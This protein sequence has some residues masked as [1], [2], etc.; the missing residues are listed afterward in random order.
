MKVAV[1]LGEGRAQGVAAGR[2]A[3]C[4][5]VALPPGHYQV[6]IG[7]ESM[8]ANKTGSVYHDLTV[9]D[10]HRHPLTLSHI[11]LEQTAGGVQLPVARAGT[12]AALLPAMPALGREFRRSERA[13]A[14][15]RVYRTKAAR[16]ATVV[17]VATLTA[18]GSGERVWTSRSGVHVST[19]DEATGPIELPLA[20]LPEGRYELRVTAADTA[21]RWADERRLTM[22]VTAS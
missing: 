20:E 18:L 2:Y 12:I 6:R 3:V 19:A 22:R 9:P 10:F 15:V 1:G 5:P 17:L 21:G 16:D 7:V 14:W 4:V 13:T 8:R 11:V